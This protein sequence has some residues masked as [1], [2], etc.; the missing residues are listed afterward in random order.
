MLGAVA[1]K[2]FGSANDRR[3]KKY[4]PRVDAINAMEKEIEAL[5][6]EALRARTAEF[7]KETRERQGSRRPAGAGLRDRARGGQAHARPAPFR[8]AADRRH[9]AAR[10]QHLGNEDRRRQDAGRDAGGL[11]QRARGPRRPRRHRQ[12]LPRQTRRRMDG[13]DLQFSR[14]DRRRDRARARRRAAQEGLRLR[15]HLRHQQR[16]R[17]RL[18]ARQHEVPDGG[19]GPAQPC[20]RHRRRSRLDPGRRGA[21][22]ADH[23]RSARGPLRILQH[24]RQIYPEARQGRLRTRREA[25]H[26]RA[27][28]S[29]HGKD[30]IHAARRRPAQ[31]RLALRRRERLDRPSRQSGAARAQAVPARQGLHRAQRRGRHHRRVHRP[32]DAGPALFGRAASGARSQGAPA[33]PAG[34]PDAGLDHVPELFPHVRKARGHDRHGDDRGRRIHGHLQSRSDRDSDQHAARRASTTTTRSTAP[35]RK[36]TARS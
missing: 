19:H 13:P 5:S 16:I 11:S 3:I 22:A 34:K 21:H 33:D 15:H 8:R 24:H 32:H 27:V 17:L 28:G 31:G 30:G 26:R 6:D 14:P 29:R 4:Q 2:L 9:G 12:R 18:S 1:R 36:N 25:A 7:R 23:F 20:L 10:R 35:R